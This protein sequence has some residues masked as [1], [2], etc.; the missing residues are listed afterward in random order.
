MNIS[1]FSLADGQSTLARQ[2]QR[3]MLK[4]THLT[5]GSHTQ[6]FSDETNSDSSPSVCGSAENIISKSYIDGFSLRNVMPQPHVYQRKNFIPRQQSKS[7]SKEFKKWN[8]LTNQTINIKANTEQ[9]TTQKV[10]IC[11]PVNIKE[12]LYS[13]NSTSKMNRLKRVGNRNR[14]LSRIL[15]AADL[16]YTLDSN[17]W[18]IKVH[19][20]RRPTLYQLPTIQIQMNWIHCPAALP[21]LKDNYSAIDLKSDQSTQY[22]YTITQRCLKISYTVIG[23]LTNT[24]QIINKSK[25]IPHEAIMR[26]LIHHLK[27]VTAHKTI[28]LFVH[29]EQ[30]SWVTKFQSCTPRNNPFKYLQ[31]LP[32]ARTL[33]YAWSAYQLT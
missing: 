18:R 22:Q 21:D 13:Y 33:N 12:S 6:S 20:H 23:N 29:L 10:L 1:K 16:R 5:P 31:K 11:S 28:P 24:M 19:V 32:F 4:N 30:T 14:Y 15:N 17:D 8:Q 27:T 3:N 26:L 25:T 7:P 9:C 2:N